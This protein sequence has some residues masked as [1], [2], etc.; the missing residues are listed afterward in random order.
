[1]PGVIYFSQFYMPKVES[2]E[3]CLISQIGP[4]KARVNGVLEKSQVT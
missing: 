4:T 1:M 3:V 2:P